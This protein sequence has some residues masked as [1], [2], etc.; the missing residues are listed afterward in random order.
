MRLNGISTILEVFDNGYSRSY[1]HGNIVHDREKGAGDRCNEGSWRFCITQVLFCTCL[2]WQVTTRQ[3]MLLARAMDAMPQK[4]TYRPA[5]QRPRTG[6][7]YNDMNT[8]CPKTSTASRCMRLACAAAT[9]C[10]EKRIHRVHPVW[11]AVGIMV[12]QCVE[13]MAGVPQ[14]G[15]LVGVLLPTCPRLILPPTGAWAT[16]L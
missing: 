1:R 10:S 3:P 8:W 7:V 14:H 11:P 12:Q 9:L 4:H 2:W 6:I 5:M 16:S 15:D 13:R